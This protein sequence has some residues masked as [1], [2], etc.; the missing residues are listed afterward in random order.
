MV[1]FSARQAKK[2]KGGGG[3]QKKTVSKA[4]SASLAALMTKLRA[5][6]HHYIRCLKPNQTLEAGDWDAKFMISQLAY[7]GT[8]EVTQ[9]RKAGLNVRRP[10]GQFFT[11]YKICVD[12][13]ASLR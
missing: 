6:E 5:T 1:H 9:I 2:K 11:Y 12:D 8:L 7:S 13:H 10:L 3:K 4:F